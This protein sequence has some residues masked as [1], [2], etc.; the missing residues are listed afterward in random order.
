MKIKDLLQEYVDKNQTATQ[1]IGLLTGIINPDQA[2]NILAIVNQ[3]ARHANG[4]LDTQTFKS[5]W[6]LK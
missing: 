1:V 5:I 3:I 4:E 2:I 6:K